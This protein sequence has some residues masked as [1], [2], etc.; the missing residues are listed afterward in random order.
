M[1]TE[2][3]VL[4]LNFNGTNNSTTFIE[5]TGKSIAANG[6]VKLSTDQSVFGNS[7]AYFDGTDDCLSFN[8]Q[9]GIWDF[10]R[11]DW[12]LE[13]WVY[14]LDTSPRAIFLPRNGTYFPFGFYTSNSNHLYA[15]GGSGSGWNVGI[16]GTAIIPINTWTHIAF[17]RYG[18]LFISFINGAVDGSVIYS[19]DLMSLPSSSFIGKDPGNYIAN[20]RGYMDAFRLIKGRALYTENFSVPTEQPQY[21]PYYQA[22]SLLLPFDGPDNSTVFG[23][24]S[25]NRLILSKSGGIK[26]STTQSKWGGSS[27]YFNSTGYLYPAFPC[28]QLNFTTSDHTVEAWIYPI[29]S[30]SPLINCQA[31]SNLWNFYLDSSTSGRLILSGSNFITGVA[32][33]ANIWQHLAIVRLGN[34]WAVYVDGVSKGTG[35]NSGTF[36]CSNA[37]YFG[38]FPGGHYFNGYVDDL[39]ITNGFARYTGNFTP[40]TQSLYKPYNY[41]PFLDKVA[42]LL[43][44]D[45][46]NNSTVFK[47]SS[48]ANSTVAVFGNAKISTTQ[49]KIGGAAGYFDGAGDYLEPQIT[50]ILNET[51]TIECWL[52]LVAYASDLSWGRYIYSQYTLND[53]FNNRMLLGLPENNSQKL[54]FFAGG[55]GGNLLSTTDVALNT[56]THIAATYDGTTRRLFLNGHIEA[57]VSTSNG[58]LSNTTPRIGAVNYGSV[59]GFLY[60]YIDELVITKGVCR[61]TT[62]FTPPEYRFYDLIA[63]IEYFYGVYNDFIRSAPGEVLT[64]DNYVITQ[65]P[66]PF[67]DMEDGGL[68]FIEDYVIYN[69]APASRRVDLYVLQSR[70]F[71]RSVWSDPITG[72]YRFDGLKDQLYFIW[73]EDHLQVFDPV[74]HLVKAGQ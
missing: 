23:D 74:T 71:I 8:S 25:L 61:Y 17:V 1:A 11:N 67:E 5:E 30:G 29:G 27:C 56:W 7:A 2:E 49:S 21:D 32:F 53:D 54:Q 22:V 13:C 52:Y 60:G 72:Y 62:D 9:G 14:L 19:G 31:T 26:I 18:N 58:Y 37:C 73:C 39:R 38:G 55:Q 42:L 70:R 34:N 10:S 3:V 51:Y 41:D 4:L 45:G 57:S 59:L 48:V 20:F 15:Y 66:I 47:D 50:P 28:E 43:H 24:Y 44:M 68:Y 12:T 46:D 63:V 16:P 35:T 64:V 40:P 65:E 33:T 6:D 69:G 36:N